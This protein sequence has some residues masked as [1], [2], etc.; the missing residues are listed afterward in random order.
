M[1]I[2]IDV[3]RGFQQKPQNAMNGR[4]AWDEFEAHTVDASTWSEDARIKS[5]KFSL[6][7]I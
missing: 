2:I 6:R 3:F 1:I 4:W 7:T 5:V